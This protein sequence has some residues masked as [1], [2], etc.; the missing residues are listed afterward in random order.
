MTDTLSGIAFGLLALALVGG[1]IGM[2]VT[3]NILHAGFWLL[4][5]SVAAAGLYFLLGAD[6]LAIIQLLVYAGAVSIIVIFSIMVTTRRRED[7]VRP[8]D[9]SWQ[10]GL[11]AAIFCALMLAVIAGG[12]LPLADMPASA[13]TI[14]DFSRQL[15]SPDG[16]A[17]PFEI[18]SIVLTVALVGAIWW[19]GKGEE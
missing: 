11:A 19:S 14:F 12:A 2:T 5:V 17:L 7:A 1:S 16:W 10:A 6:Y 4:E 18:S 8:R 9:L 15:F 13:P 3:K